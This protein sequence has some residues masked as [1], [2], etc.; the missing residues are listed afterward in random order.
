MHTFCTRI[1]SRAVR[2]GG[3]RVVGFQLDHRP[4]RHSHP[5]QGFLE[6]VK[7][8][9][10]CRLDAIP[11]LVAGPELISKRFDYMIGSH[12]NVCGAILDHLQH[13]VQHADDGAKRLVLAV[14]EPALAVEGRNNSYVPSTKCTII[15]IL[16]ET[17]S[18]PVSGVRT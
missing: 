11:G 4:D 13:C 10:Q 8:R 6:R 1:G 5:R 18:G 12:P 9:E 3:Q 16:E 14:V 7:L 17:A 15:A 2:R